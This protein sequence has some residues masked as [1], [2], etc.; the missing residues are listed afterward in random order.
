M[1]FGQNRASACRSELAPTIGALT[2]TYAGRRLHK[3]LALAMESALQPALL[4]P[5]RLSNPSCDLLSFSLPKAISRLK[6]AQNWSC[7]GLHH[8]FKEKFHWFFV[9]RRRSAARSQLRLSTKRKV[10]NTPTVHLAPTRGSEKIIP[11]MPKGDGLLTCY[12]D[13]PV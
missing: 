6:M 13:I 7:S 9:Y 11:L 2:T 8:R 12:Y 3:P 10:E 4:Y 1:G 5:K